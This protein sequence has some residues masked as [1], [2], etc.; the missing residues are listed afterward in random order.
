MQHEYYTTAPTGRPGREWD[1]SHVDAFLTTTLQ[2]NPDHNLYLYGYATSYLT[3]AH[4]QAPIYAAFLMPAELGPPTNS[5]CLRNNEES[6]DECHSF[7]HFGYS[8][9]PSNDPNHKGRVHLLA[10]DKDFEKMSEDDSLLHG[11]GIMFMAKPKDLQINR[12]GRINVDCVRIKFMCP[13]WER[14]DDGDG[15]RNG[16]WFPA[17]MESD[18]FIKQFVKCNYNVKDELVKEEFIEKGFDTNQKMKAKISEIKEC[19]STVS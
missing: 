13:L 5:M 9:K 15:V 18:N 4:H 1:F 6:V 3:N 12:R 2:D 11:W 17:E 19:L 14:G 8:W 16:T 7:D 10:C